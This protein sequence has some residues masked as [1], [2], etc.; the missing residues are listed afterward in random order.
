MKKSRGKKV[1]SV[2]FYIL[3][4][5]GLGFGIALLLK[6]NDFWRV[7]GF[8]IGVVA[9]SLFFA[10]AVT[11]QCNATTEKLPST[12]LR[13]FK[14]HGIGNDYIYFDCLKGEIEN[15]EQ[16]AVALSDRHKSIGGDGIVLI[17]HSKIADAKMRMFNADG[18]EGK[19]CGNAIR[20]VGKYLYDFRKTKK[21]RLK[22]ETLSG[23]KLLDLSVVDGKV[24]T[25][26]VDMGAPVLT[27]ADIPVS[28]DG[29]T[30]KQIVGYKMHIAGN[31]ESITCVSMGNPHCVV[32][33]DPESVN[34]EKV[35]P[36]FECNPIFPE[37]VNTEFVKVNG[38]TDITMRV[39]ERGSGE[40][41]ACGT[42]ACASVVATILNG[43][44]DKNT[45]ITVHLKGGD[46]VVRWTDKTV[47]M[48]GSA[49]LAFVGEVDVADL[50]MKGHY[51]YVKE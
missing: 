2:L 16:L 37:R 38:K 8:C 12:K 35:G 29:Y 50:Q 45:D 1:L 49:T 30:E 10:L 34:M 39:W 6:P 36:K 18:S 27:P 40:T 9:G 44:A 32:F 20:C 46:L 25:V 43:Y 41:W 5:F 42:G 23:I 19:M 4:F 48:T 47:F 21:T 22:I 17:C 31:M 26:R 7:A 33:K 13:F 15:P 11:F 24:E 51:Q 28:L 14:M 3:S